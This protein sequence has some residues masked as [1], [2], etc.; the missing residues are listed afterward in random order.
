MNRLGNLGTCIPC[1]ASTSVLG[2]GGECTCSVKKQVIAFLGGIA[3]GVL[4]LKWIS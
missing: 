2:D 3:A 4:L 1:S